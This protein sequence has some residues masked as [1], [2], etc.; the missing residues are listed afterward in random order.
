MTLVSAQSQAQPKE[1]SNQG[2]PITFLELYTSQ[3]CS[4]CPP[5]ESWLSQFT[6]ADNL[7]REII[8]INFHVNYW[9]HLGWKDP[10]AKKQFSQ[11]Q[12][13]YNLLGKT[14]NVATPGFVVNGQ[15]WNG[16]FRRLSVPNPEQLSENKLTVII[17]N[18]RATLKIE[19]E[20]PSKLEAHIA[21]LGFG[22]ETSISRGENK[23]RNL[24]HDFVVIG[25]KKMPL[26]VADNRVEVT[27]NLPAILQSGQT[28]QAAVIWLSKKRKLTPVQAVAGWL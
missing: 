10:F 6:N 17:D 9:D 26:D 2:K 8:P 1:Y 28:R 19:T 4:S 3:G 15:G 16:W 11:R 25:Y 18:N 21:I 12:R 24:I 5:A 20:E 27:T 7:W 14:H 23:G 13:R 22:I